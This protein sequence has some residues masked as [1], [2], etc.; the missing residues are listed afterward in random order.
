MDTDGP[1][2]I[3]LSIERVGDQVVIEFDTGETLVL[4]HHDALRF[5]ESLRHVAARGPDSLENIH[6]ELRLTRSTRDE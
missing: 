3:T 4:G 5:A 6:E 1:G 2:Y